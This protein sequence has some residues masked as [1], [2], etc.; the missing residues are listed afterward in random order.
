MF[1]RN[2][3]FIFFTV[4]TPTGLC[5]YRDENGN[6]QSMPLSAALALNMKSAPDGWMSQELGFTR[7]THYFGLNRSHSIP[8]KLVNDAAF[9]V[10]SLMNE[11]RGIEV[12]LTMMIFKYDGNPAPG[13]PVYAFYYKGQIDLPKSADRVA[14]G[15][16]CNLMEGGFTQLLKAHESTFYE[17][18]C[19]GSILENIKVNMDGM[20]FEDTF[21]YQIIGIDVPVAG[22]AGVPCSFISN[23]GDNAGIVHSDPTYDT[24]VSS[25]FI[26]DYYQQSQNYMFVSARPI[27][28]RI[29]GSITVSSS[30]PGKTIN[31]A[32]FTA[33]SKSVP[34]PATSDLTNITWLVNFIDVNGQ[35]IFYFDQVINLSANERLFL[36]LETINGT[37]TNFSLKGGDFTLTFA[38]QFPAT[39]PWGITLFD[40]GKKLIQ[41]ICQDASINGE[42][43]NYG[44]V[45]QLLQDNINLVAMAGDSLRASGDPNYQRF[46]N[47]VVNNPNYPST[48]VSFFYGPVIRTC[49]A[50]FF[51]SVNAILNASMGTQV[52]VGENE[53]VFIEKK[54]YVFDASVKN[55]DNGEVTDLEHTPAFDLL[56]TLFKVGYAPQQYDQKAGKYAWNTMLEMITPLKSIPSKTFEVISKYLTDP[57]LM[58]RLRSNVGD[59]SS[60]RNGSDNAVFIANTD[61]NNFV[62][63]TYTARFD[64][65]VTQVGGDPGGIGNT[66][67][68]LLI[69]QY[70]QGI[71]L[72]NING[73]Y[74][75]PSNTAA[76]FLFNQPALSGTTFNLHLDITG[77]LAGNPFNTLTGQPADT[78]T[79]KLWINGVVF[80]S[81]TVTASSPATAITITL[82]TTHAFSFKDSIYLTADTSPTGSASLESV[83]L[84]I[85]TLAS[86]NYFTARGSAITVNQG[87]SLQLLALPNITPALDGNGRPVVSSGF[88]YFQFNS[89]LLNQNFNIV[90]SLSAV[91]DG[92]TTGQKAEFDLYLNGIPVFT[93]TWIRDASLPTQGFGFV[94]GFGSPTINHDFQQG[95]IVFM[96]GSAENIKYFI[97]D[98]VLQLTS[99]QIKA[100]D[101]YRV[102]YDAISGIPTLLGYLPG[103]TIPITTGPGAPYNIEQVSPKRM[104]LTW[105]NY[106]R[107][108]LWDQVP[109]TLKFSQL[110]KNQYLSTSKNGVTITEN[111]AVSISD[112]AP[113]L[114]KAKYITYKTRVQETFARVLTGAANAYV[115]AT[116][117][118]IPAPAFPMEM[119]QRPALNES[120]DWK[121]LAAPD[122]DP[123]LFNDVNIDGLKFLDMSPN[124]LFCSFLSPVQFVPEGK[125]L[126]AAY[127][128]R[129]R[130]YF[131]FIEQVNGWINQNNYWQPWQNG[132]PCNL[133]FITRDLNA[134][135]LN[136]YA[137]DGTLISTT[138]ATVKTSPAIISPYH[139]WE[140][141]VDLT[142][143]PAGGY[144]LTAVAGSGGNTVTF[145]SEGLSVKADWPGTLSFDYTSSVNKQ[146]MIFDTGYSPRMRIRGFYDNMFDQEFKGAW[147]VNQPQ[148]IQILNAI[149]YETTELW[150]GLDDG[151]PDYVHKKVARILLL[152][153][154]MIE[155]EGFSI[156][157]GDKW[158]KTFIE[159]NPKKFHKITIRPSRNLDG[160][161]QDV[162][163]FTDDTT[164]MTSMDAQYFGPNAG[165]AGSGEPDI[166]TVTI[167]T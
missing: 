94:P 46:F 165:N 30:V 148:D 33:T 72:T 37:D 60:T 132:D 112:L 98:A 141:S 153:G 20:L 106:I 126:P 79:I 41:R 166:V 105:G 25:P 131:W 9:I 138:A 21:N 50:D 42:T 2:I 96:V 139:L 10:R 156:N 99:T 68:L 24:V 51:D 23:E 152:N 49:L 11:G 144:Y 77:S 88:Q 14:E 92:G 119:K 161:S 58:E 31:F 53:T 114:F 44:F 57:Y 133:Q 104:L 100:Y 116:F 154:C 109:G 39:Y 13:D 140:V 5:Y 16:K 117:N 19:D 74:L 127:H 129:S 84:V 163:G 82:D 115:G 150:C 75:S 111:A 135:V 97:S 12:P 90:P 56:F 34:I 93:Q 159:G 110:S 1:E 128:T 18:E 40:L 142:T 160:I 17:I 6:R 62:F 32:L 67:I 80:Q 4:D 124:S 43:Y 125:V 158:E 137:C 164:M 122:F 136:L 103:T 155:Q 27:A 73:S 47:A 113:I 108:T 145:I 123:S 89:V 15:L 101:L 162:D 35:Q 26:S 167:N 120:Q 70:L 151:I 7:N 95:D 54:G 8:Q 36:Q 146:S 55:L 149:P 134:L 71:G 81:W 86:A 121:M 87:S 107:S 64:A 91:M 66:N 52:R 38:S 69:Q 45:S 147:Y 83:N 118:G 48:G 157:E 85:T 28:V 65:D 3:P 61:P 78:V 102:Q 143:L 29:R 59:T 22:A 76:I 63:E 130:N